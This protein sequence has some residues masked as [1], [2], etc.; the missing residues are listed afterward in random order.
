MF[1]S[2]I[3]YIFILVI[4]ILSLVILLARERVS[5]RE[6]FLLSS[7]SSLSS[8]TSTPSDSSSSS[9]SSFSISD[10]LGPTYNYAK[11][12][13]TPKKLKVS[14]KANL[15]VLPN[16][17]KAV[18]HY[19]D[20]LVTGNPPLGNRFFVKSG[21]CSKDGSVSDCQGEDRWIYVDNISS[22]LVPCTDYK[23]NN[24]GLVPGMLED[25]MY[26]NPYEVFKALSGTGSGYST[27]CYLRTEKVG[28]KKNYKK[29]TKCSVASPTPECMPSF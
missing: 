9:S 2:T 4:S 22:G 7:F 1:I 16:D 18:Q 14:D 15:F 5:I 6:S 11:K 27:N 26:I 12:I 24:K 23:S 19:V 17:F 29:E 13:K 20:T 8:S 3:T 21:T 28:D 10:Y 25:A